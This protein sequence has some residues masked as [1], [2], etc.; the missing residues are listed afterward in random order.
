MLDKDSQDVITDDREV[1]IAADQ[2]NVFAQSNLV[3][4]Q[5]LLTS[6]ILNLQNV[7]D[8]I[9][10]QRKLGIWTSLESTESSKVVSDLALTGL[11]NDFQYL[12]RT[13]ENLHARCESAM[14]IAM[15]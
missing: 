14:V 7:L 9:R 11:E 10:T 12:L 1:H 3:R 4:N 13:A 5:K 15:K 6:H 8:F 2:R